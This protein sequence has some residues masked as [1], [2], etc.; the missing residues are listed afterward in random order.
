MQNWYKTAINITEVIQQIQQVS[1][2]DKIVMSNQKPPLNFTNSPSQKPGYKPSGLWYACGTAWL[3]FVNREFPSGFGKYIYKIQIN[4][5]AMCMINNADKFEEFSNKYMVERGYI[6]WS[7]VALDYSG[8]EICP[9]F[10]EFRDSKHLWYYTWDIPSG[11]IWNQSAFMGAD[12]IY[13]DVSPSS[14]NSM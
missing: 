13:D 10:Y 4:P 9:Y 12:I 3:E 14:D 6:D 1:P 2:N 5:S 7:K 11:C 8:I